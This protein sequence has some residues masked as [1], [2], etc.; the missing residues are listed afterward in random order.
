MSVDS[1]AINNITIKYR[2]PM[3]RLEDIFDDECMVRKLFLK[4]IFEVDIIKCGFV[5][6]MNGKQPSKPSKGYMSGW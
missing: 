6:V 4:L 1:R 2:F 5:K 3:P